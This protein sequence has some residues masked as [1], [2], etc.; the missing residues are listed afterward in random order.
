MSKTDRLLQ[1]EVVPFGVVTDSVH[2]ER[3]VFCVA[4]HRTDGEEAAPRLVFR[5]WDV[6]IN[7]NIT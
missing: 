2:V 5:H 4:T 3:Q 6:S 7:P 1:P